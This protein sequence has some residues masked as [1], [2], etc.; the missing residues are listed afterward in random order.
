MNVYSSSSFVFI[1]IAA[2]YFFGSC[3]QPENQRPN[4][5]IFFTDDQGTLDAGCYGAS[6]FNGR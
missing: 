6:D 1:W 2:L 5:V 4:I 3:N